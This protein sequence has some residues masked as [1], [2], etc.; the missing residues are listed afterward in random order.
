M[1]I[2]WTNDLETGNTQIDNEHKQL[3]KAADELLEACSQGKGRQEIGRAVEFLSNYTKTHFAH[4]EQLQTKYK[5]PDYITHKNWHI[6]FMK[7]IENVAE[8]MKAEGA[9]IALVAMVNNKL[10]QLLRHIRTDDLKLSQFIQ[11]STK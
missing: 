2:A 6:D 8:K 3:I 1:A 4:E 10:S 11:N 5:Y 7:E 9:T